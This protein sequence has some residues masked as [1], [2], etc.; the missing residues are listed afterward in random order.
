[1]VRDESQDNVLRQLTTAD[2]FNYQTA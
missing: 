1:M 2:G